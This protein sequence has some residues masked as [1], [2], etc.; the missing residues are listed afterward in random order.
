MCPRKLGKSALGGKPA[1]CFSHR[2]GQHLTGG[3]P[4][5]T[6]KQRSG[7]A[8]DQPSLVSFPEPIP[9]SGGPSQSCD[10]LQGRAS[11]AVHCLP[12]QCWPGLRH[13]RGLCTAWSCSQPHSAHPEG[14][15]QLRHAS[16]LVGAGDSGGPL[17]A[18]CPGCQSPISASE[19][20]RPEP[21]QSGKERSESWPYFCNFGMW[22]HYPNEGLM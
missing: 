10:T 13:Q 8:L 18:C 17:T 3:V 20:F 14:G 4:S 16:L 11:R 2:Q 1:V 12:L 9:G 22:D 19:T 5:W 7:S 21:G 15:W 6:R